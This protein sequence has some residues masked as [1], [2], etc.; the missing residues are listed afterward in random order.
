MKVNTSQLP[1]VPPHTVLDVR[2]DVV[3]I[4]FKL[5]TGDLLVGIAILAVFAGLS[6][7]GTMAEGWELV[8]PFLLAWWVLVAIV[9]L[10]RIQW[11]REYILTPAQLIVTG[12]GLAGRSRLTMPA[13]TLRFCFAETEAEENDHERGIVF[14]TGDRPEV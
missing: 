13:D 7:M 11:A 12:R 6:I 3:T 1:P 14:G 8:R 2:D 5:R 10:A 9:I 4:R